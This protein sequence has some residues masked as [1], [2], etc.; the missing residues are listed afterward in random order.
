MSRKRKRPWPSWW[1]IR[2]LIQVF[3]VRIKGTIGLK[4]VLPNGFMLRFQQTFKPGILLPK[5]V[6]Q[7]H[8]DS[9]RISASVTSLLAFLFFPSQKRFRAVSWS[10]FRYSQGRSK[11]AM[12][13]RV[14]CIIWGGHEKPEGF[15][16]GAKTVC[17]SL[18]VVRLLCRSNLQ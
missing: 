18:F 17:P 1:D 10:S 3:I 4:K 8:F 13:D 11:Y 7:I 5:K 15:F 12:S 2:D 16:A 14:R 6:S 9:S